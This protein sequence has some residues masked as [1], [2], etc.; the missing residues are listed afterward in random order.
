MKHLALSIFLIFI[1]CDQAIKPNNENKEMADELLQKSL[2]EARNQLE[3]FQYE[4][5]GT[6][7][8]IVFFDLKPEANKEAFINEL[9]KVSEID[10]VL[11][12][13]YGSFK[14]LN[15]ARAMQ[16]FELVMEMSFQSEAAYKAYQDH[17]IHMQLKSNV[18][19]YLNAPPVTYDYLRKQ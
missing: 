18:K 7:T 16:E 14:N 9:T 5:S 12:F 8:H 15:D 1:S 10:E 4:D 19:D 17:P 2:L 3:Q 6:I 11:D 13:D